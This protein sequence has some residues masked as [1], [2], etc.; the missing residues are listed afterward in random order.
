ME[1]IEI[2]AR[3]ENLGRIRELV[4]ILDHTFVGLDHQ[5]DTYFKTTNGRFKLRESSLSGPHLIFYLRDNLSGP[6]SS[7]YQKIPVEDA[8]GL[9]NLLNK[10][11]GIHTI[12]D[13]NREIYLYKNVRIHLDEVKKL[14]NFLEFEAVMNDR[15]N[16]RKVESRKVEYLMGKLGITNEDLIS[17]SYEN[18]ME[19]F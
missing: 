13:K 10:M 5:I 3:V 9:K 4:K 12:I 2:K 19:K 1:N 7:I 11:Q 14:G 6:K 16:N 17:E 8:P 18:L 15:Y